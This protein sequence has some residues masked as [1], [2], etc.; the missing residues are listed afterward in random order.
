MRRFVRP[1]TGRSLLVLVGFLMLAAFMAYTGPDAAALAL[2]S[3][4]VETPE[5]TGDA[6]DSDEAG[7]DADDETDETDEFAQQSN[8]IPL[9]IGGVLVFGGAWAYM[10]KRKRFPGTRFR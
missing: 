9:L 5:S 6:P 4:P 10:N 1:S 8:T 7:V 2:Q 3:D